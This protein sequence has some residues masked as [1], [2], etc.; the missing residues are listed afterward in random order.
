MFCLRHFRELAGTRP[1]SSRFRGHLVTRFGG[2]E[3][4]VMQ[5]DAES[6]RVREARCSSLRPRG[7]GPIGAI[8]LGAA[9]VVP[10]VSGAVPGRMLHD[11]ESPQNGVGQ[12]QGSFSFLR[13]L[14][15]REL[16]GAPLRLPVLPLGARILP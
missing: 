2:K 14:G 7:H 6:W 12:M 5:R 3:S 11:D 13:H 4:G 1:V 8:H 15:Q 9:L 16:L 10:S